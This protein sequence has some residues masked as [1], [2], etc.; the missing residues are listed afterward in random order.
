MSEDA[1]PNP[2]RVSYSEAV[3]TELLHLIA[4]AHQAGLAQQVL[5]TIKKF[6]DRLRVYPQFGEPLQ[7]LHHP[8]G[9][10]WLATIRPLTLRYAVFEDLRL[11]IVGN[12][13]LALPGSG[14]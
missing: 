8:P 5:L 1:G 4:R 13:F 12:P 3:Q 6:D 7:D 9:C 10:I 2:Y 11:V 14:F